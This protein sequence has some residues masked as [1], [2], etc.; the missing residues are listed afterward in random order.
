V[1]FAENE[2]GDG[3]QVE[4]PPEPAIYR[5]ELDTAQTL[6]ELTSEQRL[7]WTF[8]SA[9]PPEGAVVRPPVLTL[10]FDPVLDANGRAPSGAFCLP[11]RV[12]RY[13]SGNVL[14]VTPPRVEVSYDDG[15]TWLA[16]VVRRKGRRYEAL[17]DHPSGAR[18]ASV[19]ASTE[20][21]DGTVV[22]QTVIRAY[23]I[24]GQTPTDH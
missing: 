18:Y 5:V 21:A 16:A 22:E 11:L 6:V 3:I 9:A 4:V 2:L 23:A 13:G 15:A 19:R 12:V 20:D 14:D 8:A 24:D 17:L 10:R 7:V 1:L